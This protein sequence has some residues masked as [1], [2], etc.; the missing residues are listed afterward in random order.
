[1]KF[2]LHLC[3]QFIEIHW[4]FKR[5]LIVANKNGY[6]NKITSKLG[7]YKI[8]KITNFDVDTKMAKMYY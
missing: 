4:C 5:I 1:M 6:Q 3:Q 8:Y 7:I 2:S